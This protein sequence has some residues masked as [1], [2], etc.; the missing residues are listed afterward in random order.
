MFI[1][2]DL[3]IDFIKTC[4][5]QSIWYLDHHKLSK[6]ILHFPH[7]GITPDPSHFEVEIANA[8][9]GIYKSP[10][11]DQISAEIIQRGSEILLSAIHKLINF[12]G[13]SHKAV[14]P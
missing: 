14:L 2:T 9:L 10:G 7:N 5:I 4:L 8:K 12:V 11:G 6:N 1:Y 3:V 13:T